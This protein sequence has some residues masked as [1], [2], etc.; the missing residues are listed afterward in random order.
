MLVVLGVAVAIVAALGA[1]RIARVREVDARV[2]EEQEARRRG[3]RPGGEQQPGVP[4]D[5]EDRP[6]FREAYRLQEASAL[7]VALG[8]VGVERRITAGAPLSTVGQLVEEARARGM[9]PPRVEVAGDGVLAGPYATVY[10]RYRPH[11]IGVE[12]VSI[13]RTAIAADGAPVL[14]RV[15]AEE[16]AELFTLIRESAPIEMPR[17]FE[18]KSMLEAA[19]W[20]RESIKEGSGAEALDSLLKLARTEVRK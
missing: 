13:P 4:E 8:V 10:V 2:L 20:K 16:G 5:P 7:A 9:L 17:P 11:P 19:R 1:A 14:A 12:I 3:T 18:Q 6:A 15:T